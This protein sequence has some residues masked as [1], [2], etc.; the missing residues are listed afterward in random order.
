[1]TASDLIAENCLV[2][3]NQIAESQYPSDF[4]GLKQVHRRILW[5]CRDF[6]SQVSSFKAI[7]EIKGFHNHGD[8]SIYDAVVR[9]SALYDFRPAMI[10]FY[11]DNGSYAG[12]PAAADRYTSVDLS[13]FS[14][15][16][17]FD[18]DETTLPMQLSIDRMA[19]EPTHF[20]PA[21][22]TSLLFGQFA[23]GYGYTHRSFPRNLQDVCT[24]TAL[25]CQHMAT[26]PL[27]PFDIRPHV[28][29]LMPDFP[30]R[31]I[32][33]NE[34]ELLQ[35]YKW[36][37]WGQR[38][39]MEGDVVL[40][41]D[42]I[43]IITIPYGR[44]FK[45]VREIINKEIDEKGYLD[46]VVAESPKDL[47]NEGDVGDLLVRLKRGQNVFV[48]WEYIRRLIKFSGSCV[49]VLNYTN[50]EGF[51]YERD[52]P[53]ILRAWYMKRFEV[54]M[55]SKRQ[56]L[57]TLRRQWHIIKAQIVIAD[58]RDEVVRIIS[59][60]DVPTAISE[61]RS[62]FSL[63][64]FQATH[65]VETKLA[66]LSRTARESL[67]EQRQ[68]LE[69][70]I[71]ELK[72]SFDLIPYEIAE[73]AQRIGREYGNPRVS[74]L[75]KYIGC[76]VVGGGFIQIESTTEIEEIME[77]FPSG[78]VSISMYDGPNLMWIGP[79]GKVMRNAVPKLGVGEV[80]GMRFTGDEGITVKIENG[81]A[82]AVAGVVPGP[83]SLGF[84]YTT[85]KSIAITRTGEIRRIDTT[86]NAEISQRKQ[87][88]VGRQT[89]LVYVYPDTKKVHYVLV[90][91]D[92]QP[93]QLTLQRV[94]E[95]A[96][97]VVVAPRGT[98]QVVHS[99][100]GRDWYFTVPEQYLNRVKARAFHIIDA[101]A[102][103]DG[104][105]SLIIDVAQP[106][107]KKHLHFKM[108]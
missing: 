86:D 101:E 103:L 77:R 48:V 10:D 93:N 89:D 46:T 106:K 5:A 92:S 104:K 34:Q 54:V 47:S 8:Q 45:M 62:T 97:K 78:P 9:M 67:E 102:L 19:Y 69:R 60:N 25:F 13:R 41:Q 37:I 23:V 83:R 87:I 75:P 33:T 91:N 2:Y 35:S 82:C 66:M 65:L 18:V 22:P 21:I 64:Q 17:F 107:Y 70:Q 24:L 98:M 4:D 12:S 31:N 85:K 95:G 99:Y 79:Q 26:K 51:I 100:S 1:M 88:G 32:I 105:R 30:V 73:N 90:M 16:V 43:R 49:P 20:V 58:H 27:A 59:Q 57:T 52:P 96:E 71:E 94:A 80:V 84:F 38:I 74:P 44:D 68:K 55:A 15:D 40:S 61:L 50:A 76:V 63:T 72:R 14:K 29:L 36:G 53:T 28:K 3:G 56:R 39:A 42:S 81:A 11:G 6:R 108:L 7:G